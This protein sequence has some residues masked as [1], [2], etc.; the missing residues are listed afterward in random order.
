[1]GR[2]AQMF[3]SF[4]QEAT[5]SP[6]IRRSRAANI[7]R[8]RVA[9]HERLMADYFC[10]Y[11]T[12]TDDMFKRCFRM[13]KELF[14]RIVHD[15]STTYP[16]FQQ[17][18]DATGVRGF[19]P[20]QKCTPTIRQLVY[21]ISGDAFDECI[22]MGEKTSRDYLNNLC[23]SIIEVYGQLYLLKASFQ[24]IQQ[25]YAAHEDRHGFPGM[26]GSLDCMHWDWGNCPVAWQG[27][28]KRDDHPYPSIII[29]YLLSQDEMSHK[30]GRNQTSSS[31][32]A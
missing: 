32:V 21:G 23:T 31:G 3:A 19:S 16:Y 27:Q 26:L 17:Q 14:L 7:D 24:D 28:F 15:L 2:D 1:M 20:I 22:R 5:A 11:P 6:S 4:I 12:Y 8:G 13:M 9:A 10:D 25:L 30:Q 18:Y 29:T